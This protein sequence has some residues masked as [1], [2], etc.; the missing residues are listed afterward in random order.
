M[1]NT[2]CILLF[3]LTLSSPIFAVVELTYH[4]DGES[5][6]VDG[7]DLNRPFTEENGEKKYLP[8]EGT[9]GL[10]IGDESFW[11]NVYYPRSYILI[12]KHKGYTDRNSSDSY[13]LAFDSDHIPVAGSD[14]EDFSAVKWE[15]EDFSNS[16][17]GIG[18]YYNG[19]VTS[20]D[21]V[22]THIPIHGGMMED[23]Y[24]KFLISENNLDGFPFIWVMDGDSLELRN[25]EQHF[26][27][28]NPGYLYRLACRGS[29]QD[30]EALGTSPKFLSKI[31]IHEKLTLLHGASLYGNVEVLRYLKEIKADKI[32]E[33]G[34]YPVISHAIYGNRLEAV[35]LLMEYGF[36]PLDEG[37]SRFLPF[38]QAIQFRRYDIVDFLTE[39]KN[40]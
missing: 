9:W 14:A 20:A 15:E 35:K 23:A 32:K 28:D 31:L 27:K 37:R 36:D 22:R 38:S 7:F 39:N 19:A 10:Q 24:S 4:K 11:D 12:K 2:L 29:P 30:F 3:F 21:I 40:I 16:V 6:A 5:Y 8:L 1:K 34:R 18:W 33:D 25:P 17:V 13:T 26:S